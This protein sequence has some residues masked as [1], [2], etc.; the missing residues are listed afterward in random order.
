MQVITTVIGDMG[1][2]HSYLRE[3]SSRGFHVSHAFYL[4]A[5]RLMTAVHYG[6][7]RHK[8]DIDRSGGN[9]V[10][11]LKVDYPHVY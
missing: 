5:N 1:K 7:G 10:L 8:K 4:Q 11:A 2:L 6:F 3:S 9:L